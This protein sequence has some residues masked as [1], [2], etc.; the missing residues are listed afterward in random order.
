MALIK[1]SECKKKI[2]D[3]SELCVHCG[4]PIQKENINNEKTKEVNKNNESGVT[5][6]HKKLLTVF[7]CIGV[8]VVIALV[9]FLALILKEKIVMYSNT[10]ED[11]TGIVIDVYY[12][13]DCV[14][15]ENFFDYYDSLDKSITSQLTLNKYETW[16][17]QANTKKMQEVEEE[18]GITKPGVPL[19]VINE[20]EY[21]KG[22]G[23]SSVDLFLS[24]IKKYGEP[25]LVTSIEEEIDKNRTPKE[26]LIE[27]LKTLSWVCTENECM[28]K[29]NFGSSTSYY[30]INFDAKTYE[31]NNYMSDG[32]TK[33]IYYFLENRAVGRM[34]STT[35]WLVTTDYDA[36][37]NSDGTYSWNCYST[38][39]GYCETAGAD[40]A[41]SLNNIRTMF[42]DY[43]NSARINPSDL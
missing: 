40:L 17:S 1:C 21:I 41:S 5:K 19:I 2:S 39:N 34:V 23:E 27:Y 36:V 3:K 22:W 38:L 28:D 11:N 4:A 37:F 30:T 24:Y 43:C 10:D 31:H 15:C 42:I 12:G 20:K 18:L 32:D 14:Y 13:Y 25:K 26:K 6:K 35:G 9:L 8:P 33:E 16:M 29:Y 7:I